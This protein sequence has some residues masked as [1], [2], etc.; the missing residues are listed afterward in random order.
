MAQRLFTSAAFGVPMVAQYLKNSS[1]PE[2]KECNLGA[3]DVRR[4]IC[5]LDPQPNQTASGVV[6]FEQAHFYSKTKISG[7]FKGLTEGPH[8]FHIH[9]F[10]NLTEG[11]KT[12]GPHYNPFKKVHGGP[13][14]EVRHVGDLGNVIAGSDGNASY[15]HND[16]LVSLYGDYSVLGRSCVLHMNVD[17]L[18]VGGHELSSTTGNAGGRVACGVIGTCMP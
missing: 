10:G 16:H 3:E 14:S 6:H 7:Q 9:Q 5:V 1:K 8:G 4:A 2:L 17:D 13:E 15:S 11:C 12:A 18:G